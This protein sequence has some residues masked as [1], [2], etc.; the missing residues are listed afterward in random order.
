MARDFLFL[1]APSAAFVLSESAGT[2]AD[3]AA[4]FADVGEGVVDGSACVADVCLVSEFCIRLTENRQTDRD[5]GD[6]GQTTQEK[7]HKI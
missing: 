3:I 1:S 4:G 7:T 2:P 6:W 5:V